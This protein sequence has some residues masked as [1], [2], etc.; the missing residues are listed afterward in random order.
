[1]LHHLDRNY[2]GNTVWFMSDALNHYES[3]ERLKCWF[4]QEYLGYLSSTAGS[5]MSE[6]ISLLHEQLF[7]KKIIPCQMNRPGTAGCSECKK[8]V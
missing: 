1:M 6:K 4:A 7:C 2:C 5:I 8:I 3:H